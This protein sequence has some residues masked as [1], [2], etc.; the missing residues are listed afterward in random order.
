MTEHRS[1]G[2]A[3]TLRNVKAVL[4]SVCELNLSTGPL[5]SKILEYDMPRLLNE[6]NHFTVNSN[7]MVILLHRPVIS[8]EWLED[9]SAAFLSVQKSVE[10][11]AVGSARDSNLACIEPCTH[12]TR[13]EPCRPRMR[14]LR[15][16]SLPQ[17]TQRDQPRV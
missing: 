2:Q 11:F 8:I 3:S 7:T 14:A 10:D 17:P 15:Y 1:T 13:I 9:E 12:R 6:V 5:I 16:A 4:K